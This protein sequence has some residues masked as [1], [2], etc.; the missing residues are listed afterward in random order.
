MLE[1]KIQNISKHYKEKTAADDI[2][3]TLKNGVYGLLGENGAGK[4]TLLRILCG[5][6]MPDRGDVTLDGI[7]IRKMGA[8]YRTLLGYL[9]QDFGYYPDFTVKRYLL[10]LASLKAL[11]RDKALVKYK[12]M[13]E[14]TGLLGEEKQKIKHL[15]GGMIRRLGIAQAL[16]NDPKILLLDEPTAGLDPKERI[17]FRNIIS[18]LGHDRIVLLSTHIVS[19]VANAADRILIMRRGK[20]MENNT[21]D[22]LIQAASG[23][24]WE[25]VTTPAKADICQK[26]FTV[27][28]VKTE[29]NELRMRVLSG[30][31]PFAG[32]LAAAPDLEDAYLYATEN[33]EVL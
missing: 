10:Y 30:E 23:H 11:P 14:L 16:L 5:I 27:C 25:F 17:R 19:D 13:L 31:R 2:T 7:S 29:G 33:R 22:A 28:N 15:S 6:L 12:E 21:P 32:A 4:T 3:F 8:G 24:V 20:I 9:P 26:Q 1:L 18:S